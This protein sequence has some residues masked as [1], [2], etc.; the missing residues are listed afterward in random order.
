[1]GRRYIGVSFLA[2]PELTCQKVEEEGSVLLVHSL[3]HNLS[4]FS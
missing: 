3:Y 1:V 2:M 4:V